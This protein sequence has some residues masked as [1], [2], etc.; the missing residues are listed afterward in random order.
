MSDNLTLAIV[1]AL[2]VAAIIFSSVAVLVNS[3]SKERSAVPAYPTRSGRLKH[4]CTR[5]LTASQFIARRAGV[6]VPVL[7]HLARNAG[8][9]LSSPLRAR[10]ACRCATKRTPT[11]FPATRP[12]R[13]ARCHRPLQVAGH[14]VIVS[15]FPD[16]KSRAV[17]RPRTR[18]AIRVSLGEL[19]TS[20]AA[21]LEFLRLAKV[22][23]IG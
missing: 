18:P 12:L 21:D 7:V 1:S 22:H 19:D 6:W 2:A 11:P 16:G 5:V 10:L 20:P 17:L 14:L 23:R 15:D 4:V 3:A 13:I 8:S 9:C